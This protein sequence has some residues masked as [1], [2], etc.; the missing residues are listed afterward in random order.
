MTNGRTTTGHVTPRYVA[1]MYGAQERHS[2]APPPEGP[3]TMKNSRKLVITGI[4]SIA[5]VLCFASIVSARTG[6]N[7]SVRREDRRTTVATVADD[8]TSTSATAGTTAVTVATTAG[9]TVTSVE[10]RHGADDAAT[11][12]VND[13]KGVDA[14]RTSTSVDD[15]GT[16]DH[17]VDGAG[18]DV[19]DDHGTDDPATHDVNDDHGVDAGTTASTVEDNPARIGQD[20]DSTASTSVSAAPA[21]A[22]TTAVTV[23]DN[24]GRRN[25]GGD[26]GAN[27]G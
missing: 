5:G 27:H 13:D 7:G 22:S 8:S 19:N 17:G 10:L 14:A 16:D 11:Q 23:D 3:T 21:A 4:G 25:R 20:D 2:V 6:S 9:S 15:H 24:G 26:D 12:D 18:H 1:A